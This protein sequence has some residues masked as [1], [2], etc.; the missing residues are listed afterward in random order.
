MS[1]KKIL[2][3]DYNTKSLESLTELFQNH[4]IE[5]VTARDGVT[6]FEKFKS[7]NPDLVILEPM[8]PR[9]HGF[10]LTQKINKESKGKVP[11]II[12]TGVYKGH[13]YRTEATRNFGAVGY[14]EKPFDKNKL[15]DA[16]MKYVQDEG[17]VEDDIAELPDLPGADT[18]IQGLAQRLKKKPP[19]K[20]E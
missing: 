14:F 5:I 4:N 17:D 6:A 11:V 10:D 2:L 20:K 19:D 13:Q 12:V 9:L 1:K 3:V 18:V 8:L 7:E 15:V 16:V